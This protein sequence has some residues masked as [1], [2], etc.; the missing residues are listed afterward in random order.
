MVVPSNLFTCKSSVISIFLLRRSRVSPASFS[1]SSIIGYARHPQV[2]FLLCLFVNRLDHARRYTC[3]HYIFR[4]I[5]VNNAPAAKGQSHYQLEPSITTALALPRRYPQYELVLQRLAQ[6]HQLEPPLCPDVAIF[7]PTVARA[8][9]NS[10]PYRSWSL[11]PLQQLDIDDSP[12]HDHRIVFNGHLISDNR[13]RFNSSIQ[14][15]L[16]QQ[17]PLNW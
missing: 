10:S 14:I 7:L 1:Y 8:T 3:Y 12:H 17:I 5:W 2:L 6:S 13:T 11:A 15:T 16:V 4:Y 9:K